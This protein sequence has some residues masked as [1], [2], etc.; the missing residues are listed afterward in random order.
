MAGPEIVTGQTAPVV[1]AGPSIPLLELEGISKRFPGVRA[2]EGVSLAV[3]AGEVHMLVGE[4]GAGK[5]TLMKILYGAH[6]ADEGVIRFKGQTVTI[7]TPADARRLGIAVIFQEFSLVPF[8]S[9]AENIFL[10]REFRGPIAGTVD[11]RRAAREA[12]ALLDSLG[13][14]G[15]CPIQGDDVTGGIVEDR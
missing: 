7:G 14:C 1:D 8:L 6:R 10:G 12:R 5:S 4:N 11:R 13:T 9:A 2:L 3:R 15:P